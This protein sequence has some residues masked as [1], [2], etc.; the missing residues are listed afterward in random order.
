MREDRRDK[1]RGQ[2]ILR[3]SVE[4]DLGRYMH[5]VDGMIWYQLRRQ[6]RNLGQ[7]DGGPK[8]HGMMFDAV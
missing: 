4:E 1:K 5:M 6:K 2:E 8:G 7:Q 3:E